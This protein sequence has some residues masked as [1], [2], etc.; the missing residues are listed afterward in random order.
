ML[1]LILDKIYVKG[2]LPGLKQ[3]L[4]WLGLG[5]LSPKLWQGLSLN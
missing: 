3:W 5:K 2:T 4:K 1:T